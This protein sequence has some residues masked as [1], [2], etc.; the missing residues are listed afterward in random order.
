MRIAKG[1]TFSPSRALGITTA[2]RRVAR[3]TG[4]PT[5]RTGRQAKV[6]RIVWRTFFG[7]RR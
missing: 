4:I 2:K 5:S 7:S 3:A 6:G 1:L